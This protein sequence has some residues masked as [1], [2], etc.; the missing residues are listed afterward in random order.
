MCFDYFVWRLCVGINWLYHLIII[1]CL[2]SFN[3]N[4]ILQTPSL[5]NISKSVTNSSDSYFILFHFTMVLLV[6]VTCC[7]LQESEE[8]QKIVCYQNQVITDFNS[9]S[10]STNINHNSQVTDNRYFMRG[11]NKS[12]ISTQ[13]I[14]YHEITH[15]HVIVIAE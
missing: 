9:T 6:L 3:A 8:L 5:L 10:K 12:F 4:D 1:T 13:Q 7:V 2:S 11:R 14:A 15:F